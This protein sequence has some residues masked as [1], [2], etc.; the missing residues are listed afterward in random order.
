MLHIDWD[1]IGRLG[2]IPIN[3]YGLGCVAAFLVGGALTRRWAARAGIARSVVDDVVLW[4]LIGS[5]VGARLYYV[6]QNPADCFTGP[7]PIL[8][9]WER[10]LAFFGGLLGG[11]FAAWLFLR[12]AGLSFGRIADLF[13]P[14]IPVGSAI[15]RISS[16]LDGMAYRPPTSLPCGVVHDNPASYA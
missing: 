10:G 6:V 8:A 2:P 5:L 9:I 16:G 14:A 3:W 1:P 11:I 4:A 15:G 7:L 12:P 13:A